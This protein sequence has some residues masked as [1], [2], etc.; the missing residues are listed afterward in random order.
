MALV[1]PKLVAEH[2]VSAH[3]ADKNSYQSIWENPVAKWWNKIQ[4][5]LHSAWLSAFSS[6]GK[7][8]HPKKEPNWA[9]THQPAP[10]SSLPLTSQWK[11][12]PSPSG[13]PPSWRRTT[14]FRLAD[15]SCTLAVFFKSTPWSFGVWEQIALVLVP[16][17]QVEKCH[18]LSEVSFRKSN[19]KKPAQKP[20]L[21]FF[22]SPL[23]A[24]NAP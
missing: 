21:F 13:P 14:T 18:L 12:P 9:V 4:A 7:V 1:N 19:M 23:S 16:T 15:T 10:F 11:V 6:A 22:S 8:C 2:S 17:S 3:P 24:L 20:F 5:P